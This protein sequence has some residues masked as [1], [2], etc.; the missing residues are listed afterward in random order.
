MRRLIL[1]QFKYFLNINLQYH[2]IDIV[3]IAAFLNF[4]KYLL[5]MFFNHFFFLY[6]LHLEKSALILFYYKNSQ[7]AQSRW[8]LFC[9]K[10]A[11]VVLPNITCSM[12]IIVV[13]DYENENVETGS[14]WEYKMISRLSAIK[15]KVFEAFGVAL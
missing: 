6:R 10:I 9:G 12:S 4:R 3:C 11:K 8:A 14:I 13:V 5:N 7:N 2:S 15:G 1:I